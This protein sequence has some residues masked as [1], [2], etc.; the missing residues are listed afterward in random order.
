MFAGGPANDLAAFRAKNRIERNLLAAIAQFIPRE[1]DAVGGADVALTKMMGH[2]LS[3]KDK[4]A[5]RRGT[6]FAVSCGVI[7]SIADELTIDGNRSAVLVVEIDAAA[8][9]SHGSLPRLCIECFVPNSDHCFGL[10][11]LAL[12]FVLCG[13]PGQRLVEVH[14]FTTERKHSDGGEKEAASHGI[15]PCVVRDLQL[16]HTSGNCS[17]CITSCLRWRN[18]WSWLKRA[19]RRPQRAPRH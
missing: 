4:L 3:R 15:H 5:V 2:L 13:T 10:D 1:P 17:H 16:R 9:A 19:P 7:E 18:L 12:L 8:E 14:S 11:V 6:H